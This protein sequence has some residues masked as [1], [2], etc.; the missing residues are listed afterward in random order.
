MAV[1]VCLASS[2]LPFFFPQDSFSNKENVVMSNSIY[3]ELF[4]KLLTASETSVMK[5]FL[6]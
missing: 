1:E 4:Q 5:A 3:F 2:S 6:L